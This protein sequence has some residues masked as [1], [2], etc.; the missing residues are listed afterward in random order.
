MHGKIERFRWAVDRVLRTAI[1]E[2]VTRLSPESEERDAQA[3]MKAAQLDLPLPLHLGKVLRNKGGE[4]MNVVR[5]QGR[6]QIREQLATLGRQPFAGEIS[7]ILELEILGGGDQPGLRRA[8]KGHIDLLDKEEQLVLDDDKNV[9]HLIVFVHRAIGEEPAATMICTPLTTFGEDFDR[10]FRI[11][12]EQEPDE[13]AVTATFIDGQSIPFDPTKWGLGPF[14]ETDRE[15]LRF[16]EEVV[17][18]IRDLDAQDDEQLRADPD[19]DPDYDVPDSFGE[20]TDRTVRDA[21][22]DHFERVAATERGRWLADQSIDAV[23]RPGAPPA[24]LDEVRARHA[25]EVTSVD[26]STAGTFWLP[27]PREEPGTSKAG[28]FGSAC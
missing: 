7:L 20:L 27:T 17:N 11:A 21:N 25:A 13:P 24:W 4:P 16:N 3:A 18:V 5:A 22:R 23:D 6:S 10:A 19:A 28:S 1:L 26:N 9:A 2:S 12:N 15:L 14:D 8:V